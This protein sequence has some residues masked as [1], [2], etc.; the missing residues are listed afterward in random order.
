VEYLKD[1]P[2]AA[3]ERSVIAGHSPV[4]T[5]REGIMFLTG[6]E[7]KTDTEKEIVLK[8]GQP[9]K[10]FL[11]IFGVIAFLGFISFIGG[12]Q[13]GYMIFMLGISVLS[14]W[15]S[16]QSIQLEFNQPAG[17]LKVTNKG[18]KRS[19]YQIPN[20]EITRSVVNTHQEYDQATKN[21]AVRRTVNV[22]QIPKGKGKLLEIKCGT[23]RELSRYL[24]ERLKASARIG[25]Y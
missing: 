24:I 18:F 16:F 13:I 12:D 22:L 15:V 11:Q 8:Q 10:I 6:A 3:K 2:Q 14:W 23:N 20:S 1:N 4:G 19:V 17:F 21:F 7:I 5:G 9:G 25:D